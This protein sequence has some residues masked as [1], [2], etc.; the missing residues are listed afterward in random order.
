MP[1]LK[2]LESKIAGVVE[3]TFSRV[4]RSEVRPV[5]IARKLAREMEEHQYGT[6]SRTYVPNEYRVYL[7]SRDRERFQTYEDA[8]A[9]E[10]AGY[11]LEHARRERF[12]LLS[13]PVITFETDERLGLGEFGIE[14]SVVQ[15]EEQIIP[16]GAREPEPEPS[17]GRTM[18]FS[19]AQRLS[20]PLEESAS[21]RQQR[22][23]LI[24]GGRRLVVGPRGVTLGRSR[25]CDI[26]VEDANVSRR[27][28]EVRP[29]GGAWV[30]SDLDSTNGTRLNGRPIH[31]AEVV[32][33]GDEIE[34]G[35]S[36]LTFELE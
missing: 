16:T 32:R 5:E 11:L 15:P 25:E 18:V 36:V 2:S 35:A 29:R 19:S 14:T 28:A 6:L 30:V 26:V 23:V 17:S 34:L 22:A 20:E 3:G 8:L 31:T 24:Y 7:S 13:R 33:P 27:H 1:V 9:D 12:A 21:V 10:L 4:F